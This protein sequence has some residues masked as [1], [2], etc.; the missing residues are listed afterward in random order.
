[1]P[2]SAIVRIM[3][4]TGKDFKCLQIPSRIFVKHEIIKKCK[5][6]QQKFYADGLNFGLSSMI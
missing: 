2:Y 6:F 5:V 3:L 1:M 4:E